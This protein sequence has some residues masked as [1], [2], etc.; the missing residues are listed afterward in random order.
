VTV[1]KPELILTL[2]RYGFVPR[3]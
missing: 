3:S 2:R 1:V